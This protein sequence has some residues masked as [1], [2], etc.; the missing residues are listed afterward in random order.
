MAHSYV[1][2]AYQLSTVRRRQLNR[3]I[4][5]QVSTLFTLSWLEH[6]KFLNPNPE[7]HSDNIC[8]YKAPF[9]K[10]FVYT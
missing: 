7:N 5:E 1:H 2:I 8:L 6:P 3:L 10:I 4:F 9:A